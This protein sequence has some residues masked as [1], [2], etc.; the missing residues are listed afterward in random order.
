MVVEELVSE[1]LFY[2]IISI[3]VS[4]SL[5]L[6]TYFILKWLFSGLRGIQKLTHLI[7]IGI[8]GAEAIYLGTLFDLFTL[9]VEAI[10]YLGIVFWLVIIALQ[11]HLKNIAAGLANYLNPEINV[12]YTIEI[13]NIQ[14]I[15]VDIG[16]TK[17][18]IMKEDGT[19]YFIPNLKFTESTYH[20]YRK[21]KRC[22][23]FDQL[24]ENVT[25]KT[26]GCE[27]CLKEK[28]EWV[29]LRMCMTCGHVG[30]DMNSSGRHAEAH[31]S[32]TK[33]PL[34]VEIPEKRWRWCYLHDSYF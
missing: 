27:E 14:G 20:T 24:K 29:A 2:A 21:K 6:L 3:I 17:T 33:H 11:N 32:K 5:L 22:V 19:R 28:K 1:K 12:G 30:C 7:S 4:A 8:G 18:V 25:P 15:I 16:L 31:F 26:L 23:H 13:D 34:I 10:I 9:A